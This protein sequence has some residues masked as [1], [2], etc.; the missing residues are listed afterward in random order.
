MWLQVDLTHRNY[1]TI[2]AASKLLGLELL[3]KKH[4]KRMKKATKKMQLAMKLGAAGRHSSTAAS[5]AFKADP[6]LTA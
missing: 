3:R 1:S 5:D 2:K 4:R 6:A